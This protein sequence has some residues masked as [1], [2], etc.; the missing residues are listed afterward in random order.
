[1]YPKSDWQMRNGR[2]QRPVS[3][4]SGNTT[5]NQTVSPVSV[6]TPP[7]SMSTTA[8]IYAAPVQ[9]KPKQIKHTREPL[10]I[11]QYE[12]LQKLFESV[13]RSMNIL[14]NSYDSNIQMHLPLSLREKFNQSTIT[15]HLNEIKTLIEQTRGTGQSV[16]ISNSTTN[17]N[18]VA[19]KVSFYSKQDRLV[20]NFNLDGDDLEP[21]LSY[22]P[23]FKGIYSYS[24]KKLVYKNTGD[25]KYL[26]YNNYTIV[27]KT[28]LITIA[29]GLRLLD[30]AIKSNMFETNNTSVSVGRLGIDVSVCV[31]DSFNLPKYDANIAPRKIDTGKYIF[32]N[33]GTAGFKTDK[34]C[35]QICERTHLKNIYPKS[36]S[37]L[38]ERVCT[39]YNSQ[40]KR[41]CKNARCRNMHSVEETFTETTQNNFLDFIDGDYVAAYTAWSQHAKSFVK[42]FETKTIYM[43]DP[44]K[45]KA[46]NPTIFSQF[47]ALAESVEWSLVFVKRDIFDQPKNEGSCSY[48][49]MT[50]MIQLA[51]KLYENPGAHILELCNEPLEDMYVLVV[52]VYIKNSVSLS[53]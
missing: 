43:M 6:Y 34:A 8:P 53:K 4:A 15:F 10:P 24:A 3:A 46:Q 14:S 35:E 41:C 40:E 26:N 49:A 28:A 16:V 20:E 19:I 42:D 29:L 22:I 5:S 38:S 51:D 33:G 11:S 1:M 39:N 32:N 23:R 2:Q 9:R 31:K 44:W 50:R 13:A 25:F 7:R 45:K 18:T 36:I 17:N 30:V 21:F 48:A 37:T 52:A 12:I 27:G 47:V